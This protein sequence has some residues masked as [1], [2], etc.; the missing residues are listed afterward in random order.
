MNCSFGKDLLAVYAGGDATAEETLRVEEHIANC[1]ECHNLVEGYKGDGRAIASAVEG[2]PVQPPKKK[3]SHRPAL[4]AAAAIA[5]LFVGLLA[6]P[7]ARAEFAR[8]LSGLPIINIRPADETIT[9]KDPSGN[10]ITYKL[11][12]NVSYER[13]PIQGTFEYIDTTKRE[14]AVAYLGIAIKLP[15]QLEGREMRV[16]RDVGK[17]GSIF[18]A[19]VSEPQ[20]GFWARYRPKNDHKTE[21][22]YSAD[23][24]VKAEEVTIAGL[25]GIQLT[26][27]GTKG[28][29]I[30]ELWLIDGNWIF[31][32]RDERGDLARLKK[33]VESM[34]K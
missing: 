26:V 31:E 2:V 18:V 25:Q 5:V 27:Q 1:R 24:K 20:G 32:L 4:V 34:R 21:V 7:G 19:G 33:M 14:E 12:S 23:W 28:N 10:T 15:E 29:T 9:I 16:W 17:D 11:S 22:A 8:L 6:S 30:S 13:E 3:R